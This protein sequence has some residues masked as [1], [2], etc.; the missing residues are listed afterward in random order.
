[1]SHSPV[2]RLK[3]RKE[4]TEVIQRQKALKVNEIRFA[5]GV[6]AVLPFVGDSQVIENY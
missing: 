5:G 4:N 2:W 1:M 6:G 3:G